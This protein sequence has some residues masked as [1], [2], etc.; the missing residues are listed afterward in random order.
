MR[1]L[2]RP[3]GLQCFLQV[4]RSASSLRLHRIAHLIWNKVPELFYF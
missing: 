1:C 4:K 3:R 2:K